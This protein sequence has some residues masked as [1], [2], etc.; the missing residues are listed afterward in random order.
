MNLTEQELTSKMKD[1]TIKNFPEE[2]VVQF[3]KQYPLKGLMYQLMGTDLNNPDIYTAKST[4]QKMLQV[5]PVFHAL[6]T[7]PELKSVVEDYITHENEDVREFV[8]LAICHDPQYTLELLEKYSL[9]TA[10]PTIQEYLHVLYHLLKDPDSA[11][12]LKI[13]KFLAKVYRSQPDCGTTPRQ[14][15]VR[16]HFSG[17][18]QLLSSDGSPQV[19]Q[20]TRRD[21]SVRDA[22][23]L[24]KL[25]REVVRWFRKA[26]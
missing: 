9:Q 13:T 3:L 25:Q 18:N 8:T 12:G 10:H 20:R 16:V 7:E 17:R 5:R 24:H 11:V 2:D 15:S 21:Q 6:V 1:L 22:S 26:S 4:I 23:Q 14:T 19:G